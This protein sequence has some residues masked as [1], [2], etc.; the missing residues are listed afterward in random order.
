MGSRR[1]REFAVPAR[2]RLPAWASSAPSLQAS[3]VDVSSFA[4]FVERLGFIAQGP[5][6]VTTVNKDKKLPSDQRLYCEG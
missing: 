4:H 1:G 2:L 3:L 6:I 5:W